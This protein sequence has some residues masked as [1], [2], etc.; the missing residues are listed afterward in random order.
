LHNCG[1]TEQNHKNFEQIS[2]PSIAHKTI[3]KVKA[4]GADNDYDQDVYQ[5][6]QHEL[7]PFGCRRFGTTR[8]SAAAAGGCKTSGCHNRANG[9]PKRDIKPFCFG[10]VIDEELL[11]GTD[12]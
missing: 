6:E 1:K 4:N 7:S 3:N 10:H 5:Q 12:F 2:Q 8:M 9:T 11:D